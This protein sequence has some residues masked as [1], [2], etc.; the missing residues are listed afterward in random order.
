MTARPARSARGSLGARGARLRRRLA[1]SALL[2]LLATAVAVPALA[3]DGPSGGTDLT[4]SVVVPESRD[5]AFEVRDAEL[6]WSLNAETGAAAPAGGCHFL[7][8]GRPGA[9]GDAG[10][11]HV[12]TAADGLYRAQDGPVR[13]RVPDGSADG[14]AASWDTRCSTPGGTPVRGD[15]TSQARVSVTGGTGVVD[16]VAGTAR[17]TWSGTFTVVFYGG[18]T[19]WWASDPVLEVRPDGTGTLTALVGGYATSREDTSVWAPLAP[20]QVVLADLE[21]VP[22]GA[23]TGFTVTPRYLGVTAAAPDQ[24]AR[25]D[26]NA[27]VWGAFPASFVQF[28]Q[29]TGQGP[30]WYTSGG[31]A[32][33]RKV[34]SPLVVRWTA[35]QAVDDET[36][37]AAPAP[38]TATAGGTG[39]T[40][41]ST[42]A[43]RSRAA[44]AAAPTA[45]D[46]VAAVPG[47]TSQSF[48]GPR[49][50]LVTAVATTLRDDP[51][52]TG[53][54][55]AGLLLGTSGAVLGFRRGWLVLPGRGRIPAP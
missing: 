34:A 54:G 18:L 14:R 27:G 33:R 45:A 13:V 36:L 23:T 32:D 25:T 7:M 15:A 10:G 28:Q 19:Y 43:P 30:Y 17:V 8:A 46:P 38:T 41:G 35:G 5:R 1:A 26:A 47:V 40:T 37:A 9:T 24:V 44:T 55:V 11:S 39:T 12:W 21:R 48:S 53:L 20:R 16:P 2:G 42:S 3:A 49:T 4:V 50:P 31:E 51:T 29:L 52:V 22:T 6:L